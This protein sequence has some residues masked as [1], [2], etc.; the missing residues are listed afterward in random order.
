[1]GIATT[2]APELDPSKVFMAI[3]SDLKHEGAKGDSQCTYIARS[4]FFLAHCL[5]DVDHTRHPR[6]F[7]VILV[8]SF[9]S[10]YTSSDFLSLNNF[11]K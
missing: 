11:Q 3:I 7:L 5:R 6:S 10:C 1:M 2:D 9:L 8:N 4:V